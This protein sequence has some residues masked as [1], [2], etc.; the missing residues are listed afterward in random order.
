MK[1]A[2]QPE[3]SAK[4][5]LGGGVAKLIDKPFAD[6]PIMQVSDVAHVGTEHA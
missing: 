4:I 5:S 2:A 1:K 3:V 6:V